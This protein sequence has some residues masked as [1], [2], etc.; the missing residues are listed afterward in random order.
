M[1]LRDTSDQRARPAITWGRN[2]QKR[3]MLSRKKKEYLQ[4]QVM[5]SSHDRYQGIPTMNTPARITH[6]T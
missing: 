1:P 4:K 5:L 3:V 6:D 2:L